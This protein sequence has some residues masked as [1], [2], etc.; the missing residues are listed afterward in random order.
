MKSKIELTSAHKIEKS[1]QVSYHIFCILFAIAFT[2]ILISYFCDDW[3]E[4]FFLSLGT[5]AATSA[6]VSLAF[7]LIENEMKKRESIKIRLNF[8]ESFKVFYYNLICVID[9]SVCDGENISLER[10]IKLQ[11]QWFHEYYKRMVADNF[12]EPETDLRVQQ[13]KE[14]LQYVHSSFYCSFECGL[15]WQNGDFTNRQYQELHS[16]YTDFKNMLFHL[17]TNNYEKAFFVLCSRCL[18]YSLC[19]FTEIC[20]RSAAQ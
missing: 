1:K 7:Y 12:S 20:Y 9:F 5:G 10:Y 2:L 3:V 6:V 4:S 18:G 14:M 19:C 11:H 17:E 13:I 16:C 15:N 8:M